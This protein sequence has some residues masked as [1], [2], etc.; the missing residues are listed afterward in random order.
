[1]DGIEHRVFVHAACHRKSGLPHRGN[2]IHTYF[3]GVTKANWLCSGDCC[4]KRLDLNIDA[5]VQQCHDGAHKYAVSSGVLLYV[6]HV[7][8]G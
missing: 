8:A 5:I 4:R 3:V 7:R 2:D 6:L 1:M